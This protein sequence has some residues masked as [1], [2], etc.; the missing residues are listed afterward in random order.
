M[1]LNSISRGN[2]Q[3]L[4]KQLYMCHLQPSGTNPQLIRFVNRILSIRTI[5][6]RT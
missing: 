5:T 2:A 3:I 1:H 4:L 6:K